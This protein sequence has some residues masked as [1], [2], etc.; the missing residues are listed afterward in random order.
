MSLLDTQVLSSFISTQ[1][2]A[3]YT[4]IYGGMDTNCDMISDTSCGMP[5]SKTSESSPMQE[6]CSNM[7]DDDGDNMADCFDVDCCGTASCENKLYD[8]QK[9]LVCGQ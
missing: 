8:W 5:V 9:E 3:D 2:F 7:I 4:C 1:S 6:N